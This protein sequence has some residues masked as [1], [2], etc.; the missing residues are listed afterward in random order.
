MLSSCV[1]S[2]VTA[3]PHAE[4]MLASRYTEALMSGEEAE[5]QVH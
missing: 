4:R 1:F 3:R 2:Q 5:I